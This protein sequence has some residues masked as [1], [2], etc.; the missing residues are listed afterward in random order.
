MN[1]RYLWTICVLLTVN[2]IYAQ[3]TSDIKSQLIDQTGTPIIAAW[4]DVNHSNMKIQTDE[5]GYFTLKTDSWPA[6]LDI[7]L[8][9][10]EIVHVEVENAEKAKVITANKVVKLDEFVIKE[11]VSRELNTL[12][13]RNVE[14]ITKK[15]FQ[16][17]ACCRL[18]ESFDNTGSV[19]VSETDAV[20]G[21]KEMEILGLRGIYSLITLDNTP[22]F[23]GINYPFALDMIPGTWLNEVAISKGISNAI[24]GSNGF[25]GQVNIGLKNPFEDQPIFVNMYGNTM[26][27]YEANVHL[28]KVLPNPVFATG[29]YLHASKN[30]NKIDDNHDN[31]MDTPLSS[32]LNAL[33]KFRIDGLGPWES[34][35]SVQFVKDERTSGQV[36]VN[37]ENPYTAKSDAQRFTINGNTGFVGFNK[38]GRSIGFKYQ[39]T[40]NQLGAA[41]GRLNYTGN[42]NRGYFQALYEDRFNDA[43][44]ILYAG[45]SL[46][47]ENLK[48][49]IAGA[50]FN[51][52]ELVP[53]IY[54]EY[55]YNPEVKEA[56]KS[57]DNRLGL[58][59]TVRADFHNIYGTQ[60]AP[61]L[62]AKYNITMDMVLRA[63]VGKGYRTPYF[64]TD[65]IS[66][67]V[68][69]RPIEV[70]EKL[71]AEEAINYG[72]SYTLKSKI[73]GRNFTLNADLYQTQ[74]QNQIIVDQESYAGLVK[75]SNLE[76]ESVTT[77]ALLS[78]TY[79]VIE[80]LSVKLAYKWNHIEYDQAG[81]R[82]E[83][84][85]A[86]KDRALLALHYTTPDKKWEF[87]NTTSWIGQQDYLERQLIGETV[88]QVRKT[89]DSFVTTNAQVTK[90]W[91]KFDIYIGGENLTNYTQENP[92]QHGAT[93]Q[94]DLF[95]VSQV[96]APLMGIRGY[97]GFR[98]NIM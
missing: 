85:L 79:D 48:Q 92:V 42:Q 37:S 62:T 71:N 55:A 33:Y 40:N 25:S 81:Q 46:L 30:F 16:K 47:T 91:D 32:Q 94:S 29:L 67:F 43:K 24:N 39:Y 68:N 44:H 35:L 14:T 80:N 50:D 8:G 11:K 52:N 5:D 60:I 1:V 84:M 34:G 21:A 56:D 83:K 7:D 4:V 78:T 31:F 18:S 22:D 82:I 57:F 49:K 75:V 87:S 26:G 72:L 90:K 61:A 88:T 45:A 36:V 66:S 10:G 28:N 3:N 20:T 74:F 76:G 53:A 27:R 77:S 86:P 65:N 98:W 23:T 9:E 15:E 2:I 95:D 69:G 73:A 96:Y 93:P 19:S 54:A 17:A 59:A 63:N 13:T 51:R 12:Q 6:H 70:S 97:I 58:V 41:Y 89:S 64:F 38:E